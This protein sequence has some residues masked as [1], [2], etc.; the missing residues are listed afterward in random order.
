MRRR[1]IGAAINHFVSFLTIVSFKP[2]GAEG[3]GK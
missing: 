3:H 2:H 1:Y